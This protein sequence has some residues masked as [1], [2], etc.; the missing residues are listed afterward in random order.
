MLYYQG[1]NFAIKNILLTFAKF[2]PLTLSKKHQQK[3]IFNLKT[4]KLMRKFT[5]FLMSLFL[6][7]GAMAQVLIDDY[8]G[9]ETTFTIYNGNEGWKIVDGNT[10]TKFW[11][12][13]GQNVDEEVKVILNNA[14][15]VGAM[16]WY[17]CDN[18]KPAGAAI[19][20]KATADAEWETIANFT[21]N[22][23][24]DN[25][26]IC[27]ANGK[28]I[29]EFRLRITTELSN[30][31]QIAEVE[32][33]EPLTER[34]I[35]VEALAGGTV[36]IQNFEGTTA[37]TDLPV[38]L[39]ATPSEGYQFKCWM[40]G[41]TEVSTDYMYED[42]DPSSKKYTA[43]FV[44]VPEWSEAEYYFKSNLL[45]KYLT[46]KEKDGS[47]RNFRAV[48]LEPND[49]QIFSLE[50]AIE[51]NNFYIKT[52][53]GYYLNHNGWNVEAGTTPNMPVKFMAQDEPGVYLLYQAASTHKAGYLNIQTKDGWADGNGLYCDET[54]LN[55][56]KEN[57]LWTL[58]AVAPAEKEELQA[59]IAEA[60]ELF[61]K[62][63]KLVKVKGDTEINIAGKI[64]SNAAQ[65][66]ED[67]NEGDANALHDGD[68]LAALTDNDPR[69]YFHSRWGGKVINEDHYL[70]IDLGESLSDFCFEYAVRKADYDYQ[71]SPA[72]L[73]IEVRV[74]EDGTNFG[75]PV[76]TYTK[77]ANG[78][79]A[80]TDLGATL[81]SSNVISAG[82][83]VRYV[84]LT[85]TD[86]F[87]PG[88]NSWEGHHFF[89]MG[90]LNLYPT[91]EV[92]AIKD[93]YN[94]IGNELFAAAVEALATAEG[95]NDNTKASQNEVDATAADLAA[96]IEAIKAAMTHTLNVTAAGW[97]TLCLDFNAE[98]PTNNGFKA[99]VVSEVTKGAV[100]LTQVQGVLPANEAIIVEAPKGEYNFLMSADAA[101]EITENHLEGTIND[102]CIEG[103]AYIL[104][105]DNGV[106]GLYN[107]ELDK[108]A[109]GGDG[110][111]HFISY[112][113][114]AYL[115]ADAVPAALQG[116]ASFSFR[117]EGTTS[118]EEVET[119]NAVKAIYDLTGRKVN[120]ITAPGIYIVGGKKVL[121]K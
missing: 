6:S 8:Y 18:D 30:W 53:T 113:N 26:F 99:Y 45:N 31:L 69:T 66:V 37:T 111:T 110:N 105:I 65:N 63:A 36:A 29:K 95:V 21:N 57:C 4:N 83:A 2:K 14:H 70:Q 22:N 115:P 87:G 107:A 11:S 35:S 60:N 17:F 77:D 84:R 5:L 47:E 50:P 80:H 9:V 46:K 61:N 103:P 33:F 19:D 93:E 118:I 90:T 28:Q 10:G 97:A 25:I 102:E 76:A 85:I 88:S 24:T 43:V 7:V 89:G 117:Y 100:T 3:N 94:A 79:P 67:G 106:V 32:L 92:P 74:S 42:G 72:P 54:D 96:K 20:I 52:K 41:D 34:E 44:E 114:K 98:I 104:G 27:N 91:K 16:K 48:E 116:A 23:I 121:V 75:E 51:Y 73:A 68:G 49:E 13:E 64:T 39:V 55:T 38:T 108:N 59:T 12:G 120:E 82:K 78:L 112:A 58:E 40:V 109:T 1:K 119:E 101:T 86:S 15:T 56:K 62:I 81:W 71:T